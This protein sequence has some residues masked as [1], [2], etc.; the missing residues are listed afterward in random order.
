MRPHAPTLRDVAALLR[1]ALL[2]IEQLQA[3]PLDERVLDLLTF[4][5]ASTVTVARLLRR[6]QGDVRVVL[7]LLADAGRVRREPHVAGKGRWQLVGD[8]AASQI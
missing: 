6:R 2:A 3:R 1:E 4:G 7:K 8:G 5:P